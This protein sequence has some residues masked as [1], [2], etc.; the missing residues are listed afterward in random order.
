MPRMILLRHGQSVWNRDNR[1][2]GWTDVDL[3]EAGWQEAR[4]AARSLQRHD[5]HFDHCFTSV[6]KRTIR[7][8]WIVLDEIDQMWLPVTR[9][10]RLNERHYGALQGLNK[11]KVREEVG[12]QQFRLWRRSFAGRPPSLE[13]SD[14]RY[15]GH[16]AKYARVPPDLLPCGESLGDAVA[17]VLPYWQDNIERLLMEGATPLVVGHGNSFRGIIK[18]L[19]KISDEDIASLEIPMATPLVYEFNDELEPIS[20]RYLKI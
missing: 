10:W 15:P 2:T 20:S 8:L 9:S 5:I 13:K 14:E 17:R 1:F 7:T 6:L 16:E 12:D 4:A 18:Y 3:S 19:N 11:D